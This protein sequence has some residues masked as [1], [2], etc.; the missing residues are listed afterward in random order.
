MALPL[1]LDPRT[2]RWLADGA[3]RDATHYDREAAT[4]DA[5]VA[6]E[7]TFDWKG[8]AD[9]YRGRAIEHRRRARWLRGLATRVERRRAVTS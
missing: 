4:C 3:A 2:L 8:C 5:R 1:W 9:H 7:P 6:A